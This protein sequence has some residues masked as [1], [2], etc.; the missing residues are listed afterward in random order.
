MVLYKW[1]VEAV[2]FIKWMV[3]TFCL[4]VMFLYLI[5]CT[6]A[7]PKISL[8]K[9]NFSPPKLSGSNEFL[10]SSV[11]QAVTISGSCDKRIS[12]LKM[13]KDGG[14]T[15][16]NPPSSSSDLDCK[17]EVFSFVIPDPGT[18]LGFSAS[19]SSKGSI[20]LAGVTKFG[21]TSS[22]EFTIEYVFS[23]SPTLSVSDVVVLENA[24][25]ALITVTLN[26]ALSTD[27]TFDWST[28]ADTATA[29]VDFTMSS[30]V[31]TLVAGS[32]STTLSIPILNDTIYEIPES[33]YLDISN[34][35]IGSILNSRSIVSITN[36]V[37]TIPIISIADQSQSEGSSGTSNMTFTINSSAVSGSDIIVN[38]TIS[39]ITAQA[40]SDYI[41]G[42]GIVTIPAGQTSASFIVA[43]N[44]DAIFESDES[45]NISLGGG[46]GYSSS[47][48]ILSATGIIINDDTA[49]I[50]TIADTSISEGSVGTVTMT[51]TVTSSTVAGS[52]I[53]FNYLASD[54]TALIGSDYQ[55]TNGTLTIPAGQSSGTISILINGDFMHESDETIN[56]TLSGGSGYTATSSDLTA[57]GTIINDDAPPTIMIS[58]SSMA[59]GNSVTSSMTFTVTSSFVSDVD[60]GVN[61]SISDGTAIAGSDYSFGSGTVIIPAGQ[62]SVNIIAVIYGDTLYESNETFSVNLSGGS[63]YT[64]AGSDLSAIGTITNDD[65]APMITVGSVSY[66]EGN[67]GTINMNFTVTAL[68]VSGAPIIVDYVTSDGTATSGSDY[69]GANATLTIPAGQT[70]GT[71]SVVMN[72][73]LNFETNETFN[74][75][76]SAGSGFTTSGSILSA[77][78]TITND[79]VA[80]T[81][82]VGDISM[83][84]GNSGPANMT[85]TVTASGTSG[86]DIVVN[87]ATTAGGTATLGTDYLAGNGLVTILAGQTTA[88]FN[89]TINGDLIHESNET[90]NVSLSSGSGYTLTGSDMVAVGTISNDDA[91]PTISI[92][93]TSLIESVLTSANMTFTVSASSMSDIDIVVNYSISDGTAIAG[94]DYVATSGT[95][96]IPAGSTS[97]NFNVVIIGDG[98][99]ENS[100]NYNVTLSAGSGFTVSGSDL[101]AIGT[102]FNIDAAPTISIS[103][104]SYAEGDT[105]TTNMNFTVNVSTV[106][107]APTIVDYST[108][109]GTALAGSDYVVTNGTLTIPAGQTSGNF[110]IVMNG[111]TLFEAAEYFTVTLTAGSGFAVSGSTLA[112][113]ANITNDDTAPTISIGDASLNE[114]NSSTQNMSFTVT[115]S[116]ISGE[117]VVVNYTTSAGGTATVASDYL[118]ASG[119]VTILAGQTTATFDVTIN[120][121]V[122]HESNETI[123]VS[124]NSGSGYTLTGSDMDAVGT[125]FNDDAAPTISITNVSTSEGV[126]ST[127]NLFF[128]I[129]T[130]AVSDVDVVVNYST[131]DNTATAGSDYVTSSG[132]VT[133]PAGQTTGSFSV[134]INGDVTYE[135]N[136]TFDV[137]LSLGS[138]FTTSGSILTATGTITNDDVAPTISIGNMAAAETNSGTWNMI[139]TITASTTSG[140]DIVVNYTTS[141]GA[142]FSGSDYVANSGTVTI[143]PGQTTGTFNVV[144]NG[145]LAFESDESFNVTLSLGSGFTTSGSTL[146]ATGTILDEDT[147]IV[148]PVY[149]GNFNWNK[150][151]VNDGPSV[152]SASNIPC[153]GSETPNYF[154]C[155]H[156]GEKRKVVVNGYSNC[157][158]LT[159]VDNLGIFDWICDSSSGTSTFYSI[160]LKSG[161]GLRDLLTAGGSWNTNYVTIYLSG[162]P[163]VSTSATMW[164]S[165]SLQDLSTGF[166]NS[167]TASVYY[168]N[169]PGTIYY[170]TS[171]LATYGYQIAADETSVVTLGTSKLTKYGPDSLPNCDTSNGG[172]ISSGSMNLASIL[173]GGNKKF[174]WIEANIDGATGA[175]NAAN[176]GIYAYM[177]KHTR[178]N[179][180]TVS[181]TNQSYS[182][183]AAA[184]S[185]S[186]YNLITNLDIFKIASGFK[187]VNSTNNIIRNLTIA[188]ASDPTA[189]CKSLYIDSTSNNNKLF[190]IRVTNHT[191]TTANT[192]AFVISGNNN[193]ISRVN[194]SN[195]NGNG[196]GV[197]GI[198][199]DSTA[200]NNILTQIV[201]TSVADTGLKIFS[202]DSNIISFMT[203]ANNTWNGIYLDGFG[204]NSNL[205][206]SIAITNLASGEAIAT[207]STSTYN[208][209][210]ANQYF[211]LAL[212]NYVGWA[213]YVQDSISFF[214][215]YII[216][217][218]TSTCSGGSNLNSSCGG[219][220]ITTISSDIASAFKGPATSDTANGSGTGISLYTNINTI[221][222]WSTFDS[223]FRSW[224]KG[225]SG[226][227]ATG[228]TGYCGS[229][230]CQIW[231][232]RVKLS[233][234]LHNTSI[235]GYASNLNNPSFVPSGTCVTQINGDLTLTANSITFMQNAIEIEGD[236]NSNGSMIGNDNGLC[237]SNERCIYAP[238]IGAYQGEGDYTLAGYCTTSGVVNNAKI[239]KFP[240]TGI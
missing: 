166:N 193:V 183:Y 197:G 62:T 20:L 238:N 84:E 213:V 154:S 9:V 16:D 230:S 176:G 167:A 53:I 217:G 8:L 162:S 51:F 159:I 209:S 218:T 168:L 55:P 86:T 171:N 187:L 158:N 67:S 128:T 109:D 148:T 5:S 37:D 173:C 46:S 68:A 63:G 133:I 184:L 50:I 142:A 228:N 134:V 44:G 52:D 177:W 77:T 116:S 60:I 138:G 17:D 48:S 123:N 103:N 72:G 182:F 126:S 32:T 229:A 95:V 66:A 70:T 25:S 143:L 61:Y 203:S 163:I 144:I 208:S 222:L 231:D 64:N 26:S 120:S 19:A 34:P 149:S 236:R 199:L 219:S 118:A 140:E 137:T 71:I 233:T 88:T 115:A 15:W 215:G 38:Y 96:T 239:Y 49:P 75:N 22:T 206:N 202:S 155:I 223:F 4:S 10:I 56:L 42:N 78:G 240:T 92:A 141:N 186:D 106:S 91:A 23:A 174:V 83:S 151:V 33:F 99:Y 210:N 181:P 102:I 165:N 108:S 164:W 65:L 36:D 185:D 47:S 125:I 169:S 152:F 157:T 2:Y 119:T 211:N 28:T 112:A 221:N 114:G 232:F 145:D 127:T 136:E 135:I 76:L 178:I 13:S 205:F 192:N 194:V 220:G 35:S 147:P 200:Y 226:F 212:S 24:G 216:A 69:V 153:S 27:I 179:N 85:F 224:G 94:S 11:H 161:K 130:S 40:G 225:G 12:E 74:L 79:D 80:P 191:C 207:N 170:I 57:I 129:T 89:I 18:Y 6:K 30:G 101:T 43:I 180:S 54:G 131:A 132:T 156:G 7:D 58:D 39:D 214:N 82:S 190:D 3:K 104:V 21:K 110:S 29:G 195:I 41:A 73:D 227:P 122:I 117:N 124:L 188:Q 59:E 189:N 105:G 45:F 175:T 113:T 150:Y 111:D 1:A 198:Y 201:S 146:N 237:E 204:T 87:F 14:S 100:E 234:I 107:G 235:T 98:I 93:D 31:G 97:A 90:F 139:F 172:F 121:D 160:G 81:I 196:G